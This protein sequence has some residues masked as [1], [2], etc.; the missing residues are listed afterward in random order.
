MGAKPR[1]TSSL[2]PIS[3]TA[4]ATKLPIYVI[5]ELT[6]QSD[7]IANEL[8]QEL[9]A[10][11][12][13]ARW[14]QSVK[15]E[16]AAKRQT[17]QQQK[18]MQRAQQA[19]AK[20]LLQ[21]QIAA[22]RTRLKLPPG[23]D[24]ANTTEAAKILGI[25]PDALR[26][27]I[28]RTDLKAHQVTGFGYYGSQNYWRIDIFDLLEIVE[29]PPPWLSQ[30][31]TRKSSTIIDL[32]PQLPH[33]QL[34]PESVVFHVGPT[35]SGKTHD[36]LNALVAAGQGAYAAPLR[37]LA[38]EAYDK[39]RQRLGDDCV[40]LVTG[41][42]RINDHAPIICCTAEMTPMRGELLVLDE[43]QWADDRDRGW[44]WTRL[45]LGA[46]YRHIHIA[47][48]PDALP[49]V[50]AAFPNAQI[51]YRNRLC[52]LMVERQPFLLQDIPDRS[53]LVTFSRNTVYHLAGLLE[54]QQRTTA[55]IYGAM[56][57]E[58]RRYEINRFINGEAKI[59][60]ATDVIGH[61][62][63]LPVSAVIFAET[64]KFDGLRRRPL[65]TWEIAQIAG[66]A[67]RFGFD[68]TGLV[69]VVTGIPGMNPSS[70]LVSTIAKTP[71]AVGD[72]LYG[73]RTIAHGRLTPTLSDLA[74]ERPSQLRSRL[75]AWRDEAVTITESWVQL[76]DMDDMIARLDV[77]RQHPSFNCLSLESIWRLVHSPIDVN[78]R[79]DSPLLT[80][81]TSALVDG[82][83]LRHYLRPPRRVSI[84]SLEEQSRQLTILRWFTLSFPDYGDISYRQVVTA[85][86]E[87][88]AMII[89]N[90]RHTVK[91][92]VARCPRCD[93]VRIPWFPLCDACH[94]ADMAWRDD[95]D[96]SW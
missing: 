42:E 67:G 75:K 39:L 63:N 69:G 62:I 55:V 93:K 59:I 37:M 34:P 3:Q 66:R 92:G 46:T 52:P 4:V 88:N 49:L 36:A 19:A 31:R 74:I 1:S 41:E 16:A 2:I 45:L 71:I 7:F 29:K 8:H 96:Y 47:G 6:H 60:V 10:K 27:A 83:S 72:G 56:P 24:S 40:G 21:E 28:K 15:R 26:R 54:A 14:R 18:A 68:Q 9:V 13:D 32:R 80:A 64:Q 58:V 30:S 38:S 87:V 91:D 5:S 33:R 50:K 35:N 90:L 85:D 22:A 53:A 25:T 48:S 73:Y 79:T 78:S 89:A 43:V 76:A 95:D 11:S 84:G 82:I 44:A 70:R 94:Q 61:G 86:N 57:P 23:P 65:E 17:Q 20:R 77:L 51:L 12:Q 81:I